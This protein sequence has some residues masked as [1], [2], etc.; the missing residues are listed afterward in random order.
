LSKLRLQPVDF[1]TWDV[2]R[3][4]DDRVERLQPVRLDW[5]VSASKG[6]PALDLEASDVS[7]GQL[8]RLSRGLDA[9]YLG[10][11]NTQS[12]LDSDAAG[13]GAYF[14]D[15]KPPTGLTPDPSPTGRG[16]SGIAAGGAI[17]LPLPW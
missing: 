5:K 14:Q 12:E 2:R 7:S 15:T 8:Q 17:G 6:Y 13:A 9:R 11:R 10:I 16:E 1:C 3:V 4:A